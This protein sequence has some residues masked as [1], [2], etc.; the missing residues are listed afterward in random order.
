MAKSI[1]IQIADQ[2]V[3]DL[4]VS[5]T[6]LTPAYTIA[7]KFVPR[8]ELE[9]LSANGPCVLVAPSQRQGERDTRGQ[10]EYRHSIDIGLIAKLG[11]DEESDH[12]QL[13]KLI[14][15]LT[16]WYFTHDLGGDRPET[17]DS[18]NSKFLFDPALAEGKIFLSVSTLDFLAQ[19]T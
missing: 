11:S 10:R 6:G 7:R 15:D 4:A 19:R 12:E 9:T 3:T 16:D 18:V 17:L 13:D 5:L 14:E 2:M 8:K 1:S